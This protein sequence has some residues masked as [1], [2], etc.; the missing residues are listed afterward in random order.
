MYV[1]ETDDLPAAINHLHSAGEGP[2]ARLHR[3]VL[4]NIY[5]HLIYVRPL[6]IL[7]LRHSALYAMLCRS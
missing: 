5:L 2:H 6:L 3:A 7:L 4:D 1:T